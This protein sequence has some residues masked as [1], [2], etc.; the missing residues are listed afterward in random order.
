MKFCKKCGFCGRVRIHKNEKK[1]KKKINKYFLGGKIGG[2][3]KGH[4]EG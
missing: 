4:V 2:G 1:R 3:C